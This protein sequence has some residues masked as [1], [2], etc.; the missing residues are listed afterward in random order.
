MC[1]Y[2]HIN[3]YTFIYKRNGNSGVGD[4]K[5]LLAFDTFSETIGEHQVQPPEQTLRF[6]D[7][8]VTEYTIYIN[9]YIYIHIVFRSVLLQYRYCIYIYIYIYIYIQTHLFC[10]CCVVG[11]LSDM[12]YN[13]GSIW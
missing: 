1:T 9:I 4:T 10:F 8:D 13:V 7:T 6:I 3:V 12:L 11:H 2:K 5:R